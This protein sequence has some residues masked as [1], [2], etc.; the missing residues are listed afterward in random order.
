MNAS[1]TLDCSDKSVSLL[2]VVSPGGRKRLNVAVVAGESVDSGLNKDKS[3]FS[4][5][6]FS[7]LFQMLPDCDGLLDQMV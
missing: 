3:E 7:E 2:G 5:L 6:V 4:V 1:Q